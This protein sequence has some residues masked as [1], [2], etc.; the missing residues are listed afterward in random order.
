MKEQ[1]HIPDTYVR[2]CYYFRRNYSPQLSLVQMDPKEAVKLL[3]RT[4][5]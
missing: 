4:V 5:R 2:N 3:E 1:I